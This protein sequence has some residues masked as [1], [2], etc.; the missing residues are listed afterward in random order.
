LSDIEDPNDRSK[1]AK[2]LD[3]RVR[4]EVKHNC[5]TNQKFDKIKG[6]CVDD[7]IK[8]SIKHNCPTDMI[9][10]DKKGKCINPDLEDLKESG[11]V[12]TVT[13]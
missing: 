10:S 2:N 12:V 9:F 7:G 5:P 4:R 1:S 13:N 6:R 11:R 8:R 3:F